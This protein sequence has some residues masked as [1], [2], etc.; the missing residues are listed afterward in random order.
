MRRNV[1]ESIRIESW[2]H[3]MDEVYRDSW[4]PELGRHRATSV[5]RG[6]QDC[7][8]GLQ[9]SLMRLAQQP[10]SAEKIERHL[11][12]NFQKYAWSE[13]QEHSVWNWLA[14]H[15]CLQ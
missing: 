5:F 6:C 13:I 14:A 1:V 2:A 15:R 4:D 11:I 12:R 10:E 8:S 7:R 3:L 9:S